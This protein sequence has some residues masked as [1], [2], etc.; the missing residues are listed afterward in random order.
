MA[1]IDM[2]KLAGYKLDFDAVGHYSRNDLF[3]L[4]IKE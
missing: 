1:Q 2:A 3:E 4:K